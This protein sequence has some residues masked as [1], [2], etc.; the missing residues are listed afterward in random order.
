M[1]KFFQAAYCEKL[2][3]FNKE[4]HMKH[5]NIDFQGIHVK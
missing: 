5:L 4:V 3:I 1:S 2:R